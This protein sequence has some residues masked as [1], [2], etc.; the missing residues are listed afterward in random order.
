[1]ASC[2]R[3]HEGTKDSYNEKE[4]DGKGNWICGRWQQDH[5]RTGWICLNYLINIVYT[6]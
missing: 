1:M 2:V 5:I 6:H 4:Y 3:T